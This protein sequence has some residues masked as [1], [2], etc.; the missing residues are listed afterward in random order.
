M[1][2]AGRTGI[3]K[4]VLRDKEH[5]VAVETIGDAIVLTLMRFREELVSLDEYKFPPATG[6][7]ERDL[8]LAERL[9]DE[10]TGK[11][12]P[13]QYTDEY[14]KHIMQVIAAKRKRQEPHIRAEEQ[15]HSSKVVDLMERLRASLG[16]TGTRR[17]ASAGK[18]KRTAGRGTRRKSTRRR[19]AA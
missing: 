6:V 16:E 11:W 12:D 19:K 2:R 10:F 5:L 14:R 1:K 8:K 3:G 9:V 18:S 7:R 15:E 4:I 13:D 17:P